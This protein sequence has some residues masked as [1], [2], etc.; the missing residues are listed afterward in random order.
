MEIDRLRE[1]FDL[2]AET[3]ELRWR[4]SPARNVKPGD[5][6]GYQKEGGYLMVRIQRRPLLVHR[7]VFAMV[8]GFW[9]AQI[10]HINGIP[11]DNRPEN[12]RAATHSENMQNCRLQANNTSGAKGV[13][14]HATTGK[15][16]A[17]CGFGGRKHYLGL[18]KELEAASA[19][20]RAFRE[21]HHGEFARHD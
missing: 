14:W 8:N 11:N 18:Y 4:V 9:P 6:A 21:K 17:V 13:T 7:I 19:A 2:N 10:D 20:V 1:L 15:W 5:L 3:G 16:Q 12:L